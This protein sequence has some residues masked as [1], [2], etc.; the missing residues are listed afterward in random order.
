MLHS[1]KRTP[2]IV[3]RRTRPL[4]MLLTGSRK[5]STLR[6]GMC[7][8]PAGVA[9]GGVVAGWNHLPV[10]AGGRP[11]TKMTVNVMT[12]WVLWITK[13]SDGPAESGPATAGRKGTPA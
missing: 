6:G 10:R 3:F 13:L 8:L 12:S 7:T 5:C 9:T 2:L 1:E 4:V 11:E